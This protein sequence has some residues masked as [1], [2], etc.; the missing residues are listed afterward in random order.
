LQRRPDEA[1]DTNPGE[2][3]S[4]AAERRLERL[5]YDLHDGPQQ[6]IHLLALDLSLFRE[7]LLPTLEGDPNRARIIGRLDDLAAQ[8]EA[9]DGDLRGLVHTVESPFLK[10]ESLPESLAQLTAAFAA[11]TGIQPRTELT[12]DLTSFTDSRQIALLAVV[13]EALSNIRKHSHASNV[14]ILIAAD[15]G[16]VHARVTDDGRGF[17]PDTTRARAARE[18]HLGLVGMHARIRMLGGET[19]I[20]SSPGGPTHVIVEL[21]PWPAAD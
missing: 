2:G 9:L 18:G 3:T 21:P 7:Q 6:D 8:L 4:S 10:D 16:G 20:E 17:E 12:G 19:R 5:R 13:G 15:A 11:R 14:T 1:R